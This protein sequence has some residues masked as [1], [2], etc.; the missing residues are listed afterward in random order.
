MLRLSNCG[1]G[2][3]VFCSMMMVSKNVVRDIMEFVIIDKN[4]GL[5]FL[6]FGLI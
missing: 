4:S 5:F 2:C 1:N 3:I 6:Y